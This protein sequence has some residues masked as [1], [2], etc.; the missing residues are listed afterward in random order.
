MNLCDIIVQCGGS[1]GDHP[2]IF[3]NNLKGAGVEPPSF[4][5]NQHI[6]NAKTEAKEAYMAV[7]FLSGLNHHR[8]GSL[9]N[10]L[11]RD[12]DGMVKVPQYTNQCLLFGNQLEG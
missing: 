12:H 11:H 7:T 4:A 10:E 8:Y 5:N 9:M 2:L 1:L 6:E 3:N